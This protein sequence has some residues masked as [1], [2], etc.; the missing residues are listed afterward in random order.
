MVVGDVVYL[1]SGSQAVTVVEIHKDESGNNRV[2]V[3]WFDDRLQ[4]VSGDLPVD[5][6]CVDKPQLAV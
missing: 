3:N 2:I 1:K 6:M 4:L 5:A